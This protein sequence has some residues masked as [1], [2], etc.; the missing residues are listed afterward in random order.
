MVGLWDTSKRGLF[1]CGQERGMRERDREEKGGTY[2][3]DRDT[4]TYT[5]PTT[6]AW[7]RLLF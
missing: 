2:Y 1:Y 6:A 5:T 3:G 4:K 7:F